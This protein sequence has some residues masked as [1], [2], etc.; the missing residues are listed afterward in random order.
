MR[1]AAD[2]RSTDLNG[3]RVCNALRVVV[4]ALQ[5]HLQLIDK[6]SVHDQAVVHND[7][8]LT[9]ICVVPSFAQ[10][11]ADARVYIRVVLEVV[12]DERR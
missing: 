2:E 12:A 3:L 7:V 1:A 6:V 9:I 8:I 11:D 5:L 10:D 4:L